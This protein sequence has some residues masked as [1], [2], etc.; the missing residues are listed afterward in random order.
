[1]QRS[2]GV[3]VAEITLHTYEKMTRIIE[4]AVAAG[5]V[6]VERSELA[7]LLGVGNNQHLGA[8]LNQMAGQRL[9]VKVWD[10]RGWPHRWRFFAPL[11]APGVDVL[12]HEVPGFP[13]GTGAYHELNH[14]QRLNSLYE[15]AGYDMT[16]A[17][18]S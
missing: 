17:V 4:A 14:Q 18:A 16:Q 7:R 5:V 6:G 10:E 2:E 1:M 12:K 9:L 8:L 3:A 15:L 13:G 11:S